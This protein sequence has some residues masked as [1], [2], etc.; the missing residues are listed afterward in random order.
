[1]VPVP[2][3]PRLPV[4]ADKGYMLTSGLAPNSKRPERQQVGAEDQPVVELVMIRHL[5]LRV[6]RLLRVLQQDARLQPGPLVFSNPGQFKLGLRH[7]E[8]P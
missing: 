6:V 7:S 4:A 1:M 8:N 3:R 5:C 2:L